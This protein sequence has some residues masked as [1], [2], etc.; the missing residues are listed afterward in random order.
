MVL[1]FWLFYV[2]ALILMQAAGT[3]SASFTASLLEEYISQGLMTP[4]EE[5]DIKG[6]AGVLYSGACGQ[7]SSASG[8]CN[9]FSLA[10][11]WHGY[12]E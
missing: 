4:E 6:A 12:C 5:V 9:D 3:A 7:Q 10:F 8:E 2:L 1:L 11:S